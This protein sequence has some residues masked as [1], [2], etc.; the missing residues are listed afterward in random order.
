MYGPHGMRVRLARWLR[1]RSPRFRRRYPSD[2][3]RYL[4][5]RLEAELAQRWHDAII[6]RDQ[7]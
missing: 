1:R 6:G 2:F 5:Q 3:D 7:P 4:K